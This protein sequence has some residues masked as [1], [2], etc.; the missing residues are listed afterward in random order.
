MS[1]IRSQRWLLRRRTF[2]RGCGVAVALPFLEAMLPLRAAAAEPGQD[3][4]AV[5]R[6]VCVANPFGMIMDAFFPA[7]AGL[8]AALPENLAQLEDLRGKFTVFSH[9]DHG[10]TGGHAGTH[11]FLS[12]VRS[13]EA[14]GLPDGNITLDQLCA[15]RVA[16]K[17]RFPVLNTSAG[18][19]DGGGCE[20]SWTR[21]GVMVPAIQK[22]NR[23]FQLLFTDDPPDQRDR[24]A[25]R[26]RQQGSILDAVNEQAK[27]MD[28]GLG[29]RDRQKLDQ[30]F[31]SIREVE[32][33]LQQEG[34]WI[35]RPR[36]KVDMKEPRNGTVTQQL[37]ILF[38]LVML[39][40]QTDSTRVATIEVPGTFDTSGVGLSEKGYHGYSHHGK[41]PA[42][43][44]GMRTIE[45]YQIA[46]LARFVRKLAEADLLDSTQVLFGSG[47]GDGSAH[48]NANLPILV[49]GGGYRHRTHVAMPAEEG[50]RVPLCNL[51]L[52]M[53]RRFGIET[54]RF[55][56]SK[57]AL[58][59]LP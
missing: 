3:A 25:E 51:F 14:A 20:L 50:R 4:A 15:E 57:G 55:G 21:S 28:E 10:L 58:Q 56:H 31:T 12:G 37:P 23:V 45:R 18:G 46:Q 54:D 13:N 47:M 1:N 6:L 5:R 36:Q 38:D 24:R 11:A 30:Y 52:T 35:S 16:G 59:E 33:T 22:V 49:A 26:Y 41:D 39:A 53:A 9:L 17:A 34:E 44:A 27:A 29:G 42:L 43:M 19:N 8:D 7:T 2:L 48:T 32:R 40:L